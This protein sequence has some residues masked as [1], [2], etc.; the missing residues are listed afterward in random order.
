MAHQRPPCPTPTPPCASGANQPPPLQADQS[1]KGPSSLVQYGTHFELARL[2][3]RCAVVEE[4]LTPLVIVLV[5]ITF[6]H[7]PMV[8]FLPRALDTPSVSS[9]ILTAAGASYVLEQRLAVLAPPRSPVP[10]TSGTLSLVSGPSLTSSASS[11]HLPRPPTRFVFCLKLPQSTQISHFG[12][13]RTPGL[14][15]K[16]PFIT[17]LDC[18]KIPGVWLSCLAHPGPHPIALSIPTCILVPQ[19]PPD[20]ASKIFMSHCIKVCVFAVILI[21]Y[22]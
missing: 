12:R 9:A 19:R 5:A 2:R 6:L 1:D 10:P 15:L 8:S 18:L 22:P 16:L 11:A 14:L 21:N 17:A 7:S 20:T 13:R 4:H 3:F